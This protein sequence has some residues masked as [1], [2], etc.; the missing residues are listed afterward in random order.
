MFRGQNVDHGRC[1]LGAAATGFSRCGLLVALAVLVLVLAPD[2]GATPIPYVPTVLP[3]YV[4]HA[5]V[6]RPMPPAG[7]PQNPF[8]QPNPFAMAH[9]DPWQSDTSTVAGPLGRTPVSWSSRLTAARP[10]AALRFGHMFMCLTPQ[11]DSHGRLESTCLGKGE[12]SLVLVDPVSLRVLASM[13][14]PG[15]RSVFAGIGGAYFYLD[16]HD[17]AVVA[18][19][20]KHIW[21]VAQAGTAGHPSFKTVA[22][23]DLSTVGSSPRDSLAALAPD[24]QGRIWFVTHNATVGVFDPA[25]YPGPDAIHQL[26]LGRGEQVSNGHAMTPDAGYVLTSKKLYR[27]AAGAD[28]TPRVVWSAAYQTIGKTKPGQYSLGSGSSPTILDHGRYIAI[29][30]NANQLHVVVYRTTA[31]LH[32]GQHRAV[33]QVPVFPPGRGASD[34]SLIGSGRSLIATNTYGYK[35]IWIRLRSTLSE[36]GVARV[37]INANGNGCHRVWSNTTVAS[38]AAP[39]LS[40]KTGL[41]YLY[42]RRVDPKHPRLYVWYWTAV[43]FRTGRTVWQRLAGTGRRYDSWYPKLVIG[44][45]GIGYVGTFDGLVALRD[46]R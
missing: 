26:A 28:G 14:L 21:L 44:P 45:K 19:V 29:T 34:D 16:N 7:A 9:Q 27:I 8:T 3:T 6:P 39:T 30:D 17:R 37:D 11:F 20:K 12:A 40:T 10:H 4:G 13:T 31:A 38:I 41:V 25:K 36:P 22:D 2:A 32:P 33:C 5:A 1:G 42:A 46:T 24:W 23:Y 35:L 43:D 18:T 15:T